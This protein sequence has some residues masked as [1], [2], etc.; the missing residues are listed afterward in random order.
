MP[1]AWIKD[2][3]IPRLRQVRWLGVIGRLRPGVTL[4]A[5]RAD[6]ARIARELEAEHPDT[7]AQVERG[8][9]HRSAR[10]DRRLDE[11]RALGA[12]RRG[13][14][15]PADR[16]RE[17]REPAAR[18]RDGAGARARGPG[19]ARALA[20]GR[21]VRQLL[22]ESLLL[23]LAGGLLGLLVAKLGADALV[24]LAAGQLPRA[25]EVSID[26]GVLLFALAVSVVTGARV[27]AAP[28]GPLGDAAPAAVA[29]GGGEGGRRARG[30]DAQRARRGRGGPR[31]AARGRRG[32]HHPLAG[33]AA[34][35]RPRLRARG[36]RRDLVLDVRRTPSRGRGEESVPP[37][38]ARGRPRARPE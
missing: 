37:P 18:A 3:A 7:N 24:T 6:L 12:A 20:R 34:R 2:D 29:R 32:A 19:R 21:L 22:T 4:E 36:R 1:I 28:G 11:D 10:R 25:A 23:A 38:A 5:A 33:E 26:G 9:G 16:L 17:R 14:L 27:R 8:L 31:G 15:H 35:R 13:R 30:E